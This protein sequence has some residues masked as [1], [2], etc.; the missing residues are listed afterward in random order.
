MACMLRSMNIDEYPL[1]SSQSVGRPLEGGIYML[2]IYI[3][4]WSKQ[5][6]IMGAFGGKTQVTCITLILNKMSC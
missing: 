3:K 4:K 2:Y 6:E 5:A 1:I